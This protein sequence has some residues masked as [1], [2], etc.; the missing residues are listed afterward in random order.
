MKLNTTARAI[1]DCDNPNYFQEVTGTCLLGSCNLPSKVYTG[2]SLGIDVNYGRCYGVISNET[3]SFPR[4]D[5]QIDSQTYRAMVT[6]FP[7]CCNGVSVYLSRCYA[8]WHQRQHQ[9][10]LHT[11]YDCN[12]GQNR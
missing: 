4:C 5:W 7:T 10:L 9:H 11:C 8:W 1:Q 3:S 6:E 12:L 2:V